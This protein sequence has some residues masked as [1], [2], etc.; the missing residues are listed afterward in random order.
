MNELLKFLSKAATSLFALGA[1]VKLGQEAMK[2]AKKLKNSK[3]DND[4][5]R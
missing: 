3:T 1:G 5:E 4:G 2:N